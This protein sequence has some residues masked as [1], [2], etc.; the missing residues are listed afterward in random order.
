MSGKNDPVS[1]SWQ[2]EK[3]FALALILLLFLGGALGCGGKEYNAEDLLNLARNGELQERMDWARHYYQLALESNPANLEAR[4]GWIKSLSQGDEGSRSEALDLCEKYLNEVPG[5]QEIRLLQA[6]HYLIL[7]RDQEF[8]Q[9]LAGLEDTPQKAL[10]TAEYYARSQPLKALFFAETALAEEKPSIDAFRLVMVL[11][12]QT[13]H[14]DLVLEVGERAIRTYP[15]H[16][17]W[18]YL[19]A[20]SQKA[21][22]METESAKSLEVF[23]TLVAF[24]HWE[25]DSQ[26][27]PEDLID[28]LQAAS[29]VLDM[30]FPEIHLAMAKLSFASARSREGQS[31]LIRCLDAV[32]SKIEIWMAAGNLALQNQMLDV[33]L[34]CFEFV[35]E[36]QPDHRT[37]TLRMADAHQATGNRGQSRQVL[38]SFL[39]QHPNDAGVLFKLGSQWL[40]ENQPDE[41]EPY[42]F[43]ALRLAPYQG[44]F[45]VVLAQTYLAQ[46]QIP[47]AQK[48]QKNLPEP[49]PLWD[50]FCKK[51]GWTG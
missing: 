27:S 2:R 4:R 44:M 12:Q 48:L 29:G 24:T 18:H 14:H 17:D 21:L 42:L 10:L 6:G 1:R 32:P 15:L 26:G 33:A 13:Q 51:Q 11:W 23:E 7:G 38:L 35:L 47:K 22:G 40:S 30:S 28:R 3:H 25:T 37:A 50:A 8:I 43:Q 16:S 45:R 39:T 5:D 19:N 49:S 31:Q 20:R 34:R 36:H 46:K 9:A 41:A